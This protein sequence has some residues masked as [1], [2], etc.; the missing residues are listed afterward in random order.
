MKVELPDGDADNKLNGDQRLLA[1]RVAAALPFGAI[2]INEVIERIIACD[3]FE[4]FILPFVQML[5]PPTPYAPGRV[6]KSLI[7]PLF[8]HRVELSNQYKFTRPV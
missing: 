7:F 4:H 6:S 8:C 3:N 2:R 5:A 1:E